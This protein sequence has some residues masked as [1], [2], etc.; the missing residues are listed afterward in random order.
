MNKSELKKISK[1]IFELMAATEK[2]S[3]LRDNEQAKLDN[4]PPGLRF[5]DAYIRAENAHECLDSSLEMINDAVNV[6]HKV[7]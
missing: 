6:L 2:I 7:Y 4:Y 3:N 1:I 5:S